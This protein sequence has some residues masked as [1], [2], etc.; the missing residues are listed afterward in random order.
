VG[1]TSPTRAWDAQRRR[2]VREWQSGQ[3]RLAVD[4]FS[5]SALVRLQ[6]LS[7]T[8]RDSSDVGHGPSTLRDKHRAGGKKVE[9]RRK[10][11]EE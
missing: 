10:R 11:E 4:Q 8:A 5:L 6:P 1:D 7:Q 2:P 9:D 3:L